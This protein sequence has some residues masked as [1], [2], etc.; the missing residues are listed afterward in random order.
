[1][2][3]VNKVII[4]GHL[5]ADPESRSFPGGGNVTNIRVATTERYKDRDGNQQEATE[6]NRVSLFN[7][8]GEVAD[9]YLNK[10]SQV[11]IEG[12][13]RTRKYQDKDGRDA[14][15]TEIVADQMQMLGAKPENRQQDQGGHGRDNGGRSQRQEPQ[16]SNQ[17]QPTGNN[18]NQRDA[19]GFGD[20]PDDIP[21]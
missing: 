13:L 4:I 15:A 2:A 3:S 16:R 5:G 9:Q 11:Y 17:R 19:G 8:L 20:M 18:R 12:K 21:Y 6:W 10:G 14:Y 1:M 7:R